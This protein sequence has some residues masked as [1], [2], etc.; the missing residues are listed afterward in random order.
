MADRITVTLHQLVS[1]LDSYA[2]Q[3]LR[4]RH[5][6]SFNQFQ[7]LAA[8]AEQGPIDITGLA[9]C[10]R[11]S[12]AAVSKRVPA[13]EAEGWLR[14]AD[15][16]SHARRVI[17]SLTPKAVKLVREAG[18]ELDAEFGALFADPRL[19]EQ[20]IDVN[21]LNRQL[22]VLTEMILLKGAPS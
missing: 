20:R 18:G 6:V 22:A 11:V 17:L 19:A 14:T 12:K 16:P 5:G 15:D 4:L 7:F 10:L 3:A 1:A 21:A 2:D 9:H 13:L 8:V